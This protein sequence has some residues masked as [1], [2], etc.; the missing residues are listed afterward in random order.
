MNA[1]SDSDGHLRDDLAPGETAAGP[2][3]KKTYSSPQLLEWG[4]ITDLTHGQPFTGNNDF[5]KKGG[6]RFV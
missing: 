2:Q 1:D 4:S 5:P 3:K 6:S